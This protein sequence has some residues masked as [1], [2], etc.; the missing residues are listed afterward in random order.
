VAAAKEPIDEGLLAEVIGAIGSDRRR[1]WVSGL[2]QNNLYSSG[3]SEVTRD[4]PR[5]QSLY[6]HPN[7][8]ID[9]AD[10]EH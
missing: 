3:S 10:R 8:S 6:T 1:H 9:D 4:A 2:P 5:S 7:G